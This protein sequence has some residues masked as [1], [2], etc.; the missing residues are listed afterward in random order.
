MCCES[1]RDSVAQ[2]SQSLYLEYLDLICSPH[3]GQDA[4]FTAYDTLDR[5]MRCPNKLTW[6]DPSP[7]AGLG[8]LLLLSFGIVSDPKSVEI[9]SSIDFHP[10]KILHSKETVN[11]WISTIFNPFCARYD[12]DI[13]HTQ[14]LVE[15]KLIAA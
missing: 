8:M 11:T 4:D 7:T 14:S 2:K 13:A 15:A 10:D 5:K 3:A 9:P 12:F 1:L 6:A